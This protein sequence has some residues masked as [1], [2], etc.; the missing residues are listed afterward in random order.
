MA[1]SEYSISIVIIVEPPLLTSSSAA[2]GES[3]RKYISIRDSS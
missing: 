2:V 3:L 1:C